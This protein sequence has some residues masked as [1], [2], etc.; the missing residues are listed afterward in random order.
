MELEL[1]GALPPDLV[2]ERQAKRA[3][4][5]RTIPIHILPWQPPLLTSTLG[6][7]SSPSLGPLLS[8]PAACRRLPAGKPR[9]AAAAAAAQAGAPNRQGRRAAAPPPPHHTLRQPIPPAVITRLAR[10]LPPLLGRRVGRRWCR[11]GRDD[12][13]G[14]TAV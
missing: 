8:H 4:Q 1:E 14:A 5:A 10:R 12:G 7:P 6:L 13:G 2:R 11:G 9:A 3:M